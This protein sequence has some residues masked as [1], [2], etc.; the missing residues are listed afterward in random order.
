[1]EDKKSQLTWRPLERGGARGQERGWGQSCMS[2]ISRWG[3]VV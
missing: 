2:I 1:M 3:F